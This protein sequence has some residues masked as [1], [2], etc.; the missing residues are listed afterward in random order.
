MTDT[1]I[2]TSTFRC[3][4]CGHRFLAAHLWQGAEALARGDF[5]AQWHLGNQR[6]LIL[7]PLV[8]SAPCA[9]HAPLPSLKDWWT[10]HRPTLGMSYATLTQFV[11]A[12]SDGIEE[13]QRPER[14]PLP[15]TPL[16]HKRR[17]EA[18]RVAR[19][20][21][22]EGVRASGCAVPEVRLA[23]CDVCAQEANA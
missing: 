12:H 17:L 3:A 5:V 6:R 2:G 10:T 14:A 15:L 23:P 1:Y 4:H 21:A 7:W 13:L 9:A 16:L 19:C 22:Q 11:H 8:C 18:Q 20:L